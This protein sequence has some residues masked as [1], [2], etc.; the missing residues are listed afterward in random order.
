MSVQLK[1]TL[2]SFT[3]KLPLEVGQFCT[4]GRSSKSTFQI[5][6]DNISSLHCKLTLTDNCIKLE[7]LGSKNGTYLNGVKVESGTVFLGDEIRMG[8][9]QILIDIESLDDKWKIALIKRDKAYQE[10]KLEI[11]KIEYPKNDFIY[12]EETRNPIRTLKKIDLEDIHEKHSLRSKAS[13]TINYLIL[14]FLLVLPPI[15]IMNF[16]N[17]EINHQV[18]A[19]AII[20]PIFLALYYYM[21]YRFLKLTIGEK[22]AGIEKLY[23]NQN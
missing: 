12:N 14:L 13:Y 23:K 15:T 4:L 6:D 11:Q 18:I 3:S 5:D 1:V 9:V 16:S 21:N 22:L 2:K 19:I 20:E 8:K 10:P 17:L 7:D